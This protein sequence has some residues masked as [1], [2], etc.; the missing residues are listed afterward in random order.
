MAINFRYARE[1]VA[2]IY[3]ER[4][5]L[6]N[7]ERKGVEML[8]D[9][10]RRKDK[11]KSR[12][13]KNSEDTPEDNKGVG[14]GMIYIGVDP[15]LRGSIS[16]IDPEGII[17]A[18]PIPTITIQKNN[19]NRT[20]YNHT[21]VRNIFR[22]LGKHDCFAVL[23]EQ[24]PRPTYYKDKQGKVKKQGATSLYTTGCG[25]C[26]LKQ[27]LIDFEIPHE[28]V[29]S[30]EWQKTF[31]IT[32]GKG[33]T[34]TQSIETCKRLFPNLSLLPTARSRKESDGLADAALIAEFA[35][36]RYGGRQ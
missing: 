29:L 5:T 36:R 11:S 1:D 21:E 8:C 28:I 27:A 31:G 32:G 25:F 13:N 34:K 19:K 12:I 15:G 7:L 30:K 22:E 23:E 33:N 24:Q 26:L 14:V 17:T 35:K 6:K 20:T 18:I 10:R 16:T 9:E 3:D 4:K 2:C